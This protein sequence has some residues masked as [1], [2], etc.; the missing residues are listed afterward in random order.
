MPQD[1]LTLGQVRDVE[2]LE[3]RGILDCIECGGCDYVCPSAIPLTERLVRAKHQVWQQH[4]A[5]RQAD[6][7]RKRFEAREQRL[8]RETQEQNRALDQQIG[9]ISIEDLVRR[10]KS[11]ETRSAD[12]NEDG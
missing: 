1:L 7:A 8:A 3:A 6:H 10:M 4:A 2:Q 12:D 11:R 5:A 9:E